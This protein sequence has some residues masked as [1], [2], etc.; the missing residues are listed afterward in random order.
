MLPSPGTR[1]R[2]RRSVGEGGAGLAFL[3]PLTPPGVVTVN[4]GRRQDTRGSLPRKAVSGHRRNSGGR[5][6]SCCVCATVKRKELTF[7]ARYGNVDCFFTLL[8]F[9]VWFVD[10]LT[11]HYSCLF[12]LI[13]LSFSFF[14][15]FNPFYFYNFL[16]SSYFM[17]VCSLT[18]R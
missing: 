8:V 18:C 2:D 14:L 11:F 10:Y 13:H 3:A 1:W 6:C 9:L 15:T 17:Y 4:E 16:L 12:L 7:F 5:C